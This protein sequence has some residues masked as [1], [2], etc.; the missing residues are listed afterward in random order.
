MSALA[1]EVR[2]HR[3]R[4]GLK[5]PGAADWL[6]ANGIP[7]PLAPNTWTHAEKSDVA[8]ALLVARLGASEF[9]LE[10]GA[11]GTALQQISRS[12]E[13]PQIGRA[14]CRERVYVLV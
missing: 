9:F 7:V 14:S 12:L 13:E 2:E 1:L 11:A 4:V 6:A 8:A 10:D 3:H 5:G